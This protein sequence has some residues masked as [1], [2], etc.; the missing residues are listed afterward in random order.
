MESEPGLC[1]VRRVVPGW[2][3]VEVWASGRGVRRVRLGAT[4]EADPPE[5][6]PPRA[7][8]YAER[9]LTEIA[10][11]LAGDRREFTVPL[12]PA[13]LPRFPWRVLQTCREIP[14]GQTVSYG[15][16][17]RR[18]GSPRAA[19]A[20]GQALARNPWPLLVPCHRV[21]A[22]GG[23]LGGFQGGLEL[24]RRLLAGEQRLGR[25]GP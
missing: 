18:A 24:K 2:G 8:A 7:R 9:A 14:Y 11:Y 19:R 3:P 12:D 23:G 10:E 5:P 6:G 20:V 22:A 17:A 21:L 1:R 13:A 4:P 15:E 25:D 16:L